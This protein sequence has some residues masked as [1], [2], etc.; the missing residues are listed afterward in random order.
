MNSGDQLFGTRAAVQIRYDGSLKKLT[1]K[2]SDEL[3]HAAFH[4]E[5]DMD[6]PHVEFAMCEALGFEMWL[7]HSER[8][9]GYNYELRMETCHCDPE[10]MSDRMLDISPWLARYV[11]EIGGIDAVVSA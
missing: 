2:L 4:F 7:N 8:T 1:S 9:S 5:T 11:R 10:I 3:F 6:P